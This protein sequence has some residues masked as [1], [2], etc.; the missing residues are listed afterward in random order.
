[1]SDLTRNRPNEHKGIWDVQNHKEHTFEF[2]LKFFFLVKFG[3]V[4]QTSGSLAGP[5]TKMLP[6]CSRIGN[7][8]VDTIKELAC[9]KF[10]TNTD[11]EQM[12][13]QVVFLCILFPHQPSIISMIQRIGVGVKNMKLL[14]TVLSSLSSHLGQ[15][16]LYTFSTIPLRARDKASHLYEI[17][18][19]FLILPVYCR[20]MK[21]TSRRRSE[22]YRF[23]SIPQIELISVT[24]QMEIKRNR[25]YKP[26]RSYFTTK[27]RRKY[28][29]KIMTRSRKQILINISLSRSDKTC[30]GW[31]L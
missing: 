7:E 9:R 31:L 17:T 8:W 1:M 10:C 22:G 23:S 12:A 18:N 28:A 20:N 13:P 5:A 11:S 3:L 21:N 4:I 16:I 26:L 15:C 24:G 19:W 30:Y 6:N 29:I 27:I 25:I 14:Y 2:F